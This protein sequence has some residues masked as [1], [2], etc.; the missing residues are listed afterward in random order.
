M[1]R[2]LIVG[3]GLAGANLAFQLY[4]DGIPFTVIDKRNNS[5]S[6]RVAAGLINP[7]VFRR[8]NKSWMVDD[9]VP[10]MQSVYKDIEGLLDVTVLHDK[11]ITKLLSKDE[12][13]F[14]QQKTQGDD[15][16]DYIGNVCKGTGSLSGVNKYYGTGS[17]LNGGYC[18]IALMLDALQKY[19]LDEG[20]FKEGHFDYEKI[21]CNADSFVYDQEKYSHVIFCQGYDVLHNPYF[22]NVG[23]KP[24]KGEIL[25]VKID[26]FEKEKVV[27]KNMFVLPISDNIYKVGATYDWRDLS[28]RTTSEGQRFLLEKLK[29]ITALDVTVIE[30]VAGVRPTVSDRRPVLGFLPE[31]PN[32]GVFNGLGTKGVMIAPYF[33][34]E[35]VKL[36]MDAD[37]KVHPEVSLDRFL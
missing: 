35:M 11:C 23:L 2:V 14:W 13:E 16:V 36:I 6:S 27:N 29:D 17:V 9:L 28:D 34:K 3:H 7:I 1:K 12:Y 25:T 24:V 22:S 5:S 32:M 4:K 31:K 26:G 15:L 8:L 33:A 21:T 30:H 10:V 37:Y 18:D 20:V 19:W